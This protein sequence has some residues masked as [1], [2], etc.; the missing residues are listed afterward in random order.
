[1]NTIASKVNSRLARL[2]RAQHHARAH[3]E[4]LTEQARSLDHQSASA[5]SRLRRAYLGAK[6]AGARVEAGEQYLRA[7]GLRAKAHRLRATVEQVGRRLD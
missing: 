3:G 6:D 4:A 5:A 1:M 7:V 2:A